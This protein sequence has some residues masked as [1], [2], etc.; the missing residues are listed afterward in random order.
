LEKERRRLEILLKIFKNSSEYKKI[1]QA[2][3][4]AV[5][6]S[7]LNRKD[8][9]KLAVSCVTET[10]RKDPDKFYFL[11]KNDQYVSSQLNSSHIYR[12]LILEDAEK[13]FELMVRDLT[14]KVIS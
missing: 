9:L 7:L 3:E 11:V 4:E 13:L 14:S 8:L 5:V 2:A 10:M 1:K 12:A 6:N